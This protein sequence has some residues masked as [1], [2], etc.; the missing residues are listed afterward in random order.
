VTIR[1]N[2]PLRGVTAVGL[3]DPLPPP[4]AEIPEGADLTEED[5][6]AGGT[7]ELAVA[8]V[9]TPVALQ[10]PPLEMT[11]QDGEAAQ[12][13]AGGEEAENG[14]ESEVL[15]VDRDFP[16]PPQAPEI[17]ERAG[18]GA[19]EDD[20]GGPLSDSGVL[21]VAPV[22]P[23]PVL[24][25]P[26]LPAPVLPAPVLPAPVLPAPV[27]PAPVLPAP[28]EPAAITE[29]WER[30]PSPQDGQFEE[31]SESAAPA[32]DEEQERKGH[33]VAV[34]LAAEFELRLQ[35]LDVERKAVE[36]A[37][38]G[39]TEAVQA[40]HSERRHILAEMQQAL[41]ELALAITG[42]LLHVKISADDFA[43]E[44][45]V[46]QVVEKLGVTE[47]VTVRLNP[48]DL[49]LLHKRLGDRTLVVD[50]GSQMQ[51]VPD[52]SLDRG[53]CVA[54]AGDL[55][56]SSRLRDK[57]AEIRALLSDPDSCWH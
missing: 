37:V 6:H 29:R 16:P 27:L 20:P 24:P 45:L 15:P 21:A 28:A 26:V 55:S 30:E 22:L 49:A 9:D 40:F 1:F 10:S 51:F 44:S 18:K 33:E 57:L 19:K 7:S 41:T 38:A 2:R 36:R 31:I 11:E 14:S 48:T 52:Q 54:S 39:M 35:Q 13:T 34:A 23:A 32:V 53:D 46:Q 5:D 8:V 47:Q 12:E 56:V 4:P 43:V 3:D 25:A 17:L 42:R 50:A